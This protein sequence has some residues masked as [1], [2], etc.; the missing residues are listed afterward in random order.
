MENT[1]KTAGNTKVTVT[2]KYE[3]FYGSTLSKDEIDIADIIRDATTIKDI[4]VKMSESTRIR[5][6]LGFFDRKKKD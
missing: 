5:R 4:D 3:A 6:P 1:V 2:V